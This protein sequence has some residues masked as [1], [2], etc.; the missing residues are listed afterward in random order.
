MCSSFLLNLIIEGSHRHSVIAA[1]FTVS[2][3]ETEDGTTKGIREKVVEKLKQLGAKEQLFMCVTGPAGAVKSTAIEVA[4][5]LCFEFCTTMGII[6][7][8][9]TCLFTAITGCTAVLLQ[10]WLC[11]VQHISTQNQNNI[12]PEM[13]PTW[14][15][16]QMLNIDEISFSTCDQMG[17]LNKVLNPIRLNCTMTT[18]SC[19]PVLFL[20]STQ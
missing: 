18:K 10:G 4:Q 7:G 12:F 5:Q 15:Q 2:D 16:V 1:R 3:E 6:W 9:N 19:H 8:D 20:D 17:K 14:E 11:I 13:L